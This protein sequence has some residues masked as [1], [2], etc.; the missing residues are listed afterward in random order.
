MPVKL[1]T[2]ESTFA[3]DEGLHL[4]PGVLLSWLTAQ[5]ELAG[6]TQ[7]ETLELRRPDGSVL[8]T[9]LLQYGASVT[10]GEDGSFSVPTDEKGPIWVIVFTLPPNLRPED[11]PP[12]TEVWVVR[13]AEN[14]NDTD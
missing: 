13:S 4:R 3:S 11:A 6:L 10:R 8:P 14:G 7:G 2:V 1:L 12:G 5:P 9:T